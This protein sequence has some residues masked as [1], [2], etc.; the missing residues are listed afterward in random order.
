MRNIDG[1][2]MF[3]SVESAKC[4]SRPVGVEDRLVVFV[5]E[6]CFSAFR[7]GPVR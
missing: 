1:E 6:L 4:D 7:G 5:N 3:V 2:E